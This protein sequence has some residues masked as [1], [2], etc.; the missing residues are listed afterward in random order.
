MTQKELQL[1]DQRLLMAKAMRDTMALLGSMSKEFKPNTFTRKMTEV[2]LDLMIAAHLSGE[3]RVRKQSGI[4]LDSALGQAVAVMESRV[5]A[6]REVLKRQYEMPALRMANDVTQKVQRKLLDTQLLITREGL[7]TDA[8]TAVL[9]E[10]MIASGVTIK[11]SYMVENIYRTQ[12]AIAYNAGKFKTEQLP[13]IQELLWGYTYFTAGDDRVR[14][15]HAVLD[16]TSLP[17]EDAFWKR[18]YPPNGWSCRCTVVAEYETGDT[19]AAPDDM[20]EADENFMVNF[21]EIL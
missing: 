13:E 7:H 4:R 14:E 12:S 21:G 18:W 6:K 3:L 19:V 10:S 20:P 1:R 11:N 15:E 2:S 8:A 5:S 17:K 9:E 16:G